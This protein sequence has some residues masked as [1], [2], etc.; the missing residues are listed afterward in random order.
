MSAP[1]VNDALFVAVLA[2]IEREPE[3]WDQGDWGPIGPVCNTSYCFAGWAAVLSGAKQRFLVDGNGD[4][5]AQF[6]RRK[7]KVSAAAVRLLGIKPELRSWYDDSA[8][9]LF[10]ESNDLDDLYRISAA[11]MG[12]AESTLREKVA[13]EVADGGL[14]S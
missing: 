12:I 14:Q 2:Q 9:H 3:T 8:S 11:E 7:E 1:V 6:G 4:V 5:L 13:A 10:D